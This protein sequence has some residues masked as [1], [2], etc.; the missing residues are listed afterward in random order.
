MYVIRV[1]LV[2]LGSLLSKLKKTFVPYPSRVIVV[3]FY[4]KGLKNLE[5]LG[6]LEF[7]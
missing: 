7:F 4:P 2:T 3:N 6:T 5:H 1:L